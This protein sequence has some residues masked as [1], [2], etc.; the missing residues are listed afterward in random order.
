MKSPVLCIQDRGFVFQMEC[1]KI[2]RNS[3]N[4]PRLVWKFQ[5]TNFFSKSSGFRTKKH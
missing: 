5:S 3:N 4:N 1:T 2:L